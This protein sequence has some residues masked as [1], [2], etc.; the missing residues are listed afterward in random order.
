MF[1]EFNKPFAFN[2]DKVKAQQKEVYICVGADCTKRGS[3]G[4]LRR[5][6]E[7]YFAP[8]Q[9]GTYNCIGLCHKNYAFRYRDKNY[10]VSCPEELRRMFSTK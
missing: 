6:I 1:E 2:S 8:E 4:R 10:S 9:I 3:Q 5:E 7:K